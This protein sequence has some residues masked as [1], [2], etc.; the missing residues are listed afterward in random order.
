M[1]NNTLQMWLP[2]S[3]SERVLLPPATLG[4]PLLR[5]A[6]AT[7]FQN[8]LQGVPLCFRMSLIGDK[9]SSFAFWKSVK[10]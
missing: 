8:G 1:I 10:K 4:D 2:S 6:A 7:R 5:L 3:A 9:S